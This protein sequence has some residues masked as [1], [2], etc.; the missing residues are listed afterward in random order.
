MSRHAAMALIL[1]APLAA[2]IQPAQAQ[3]AQ[4]PDWPCV[5]VLVPELAMGQMW[6]GPP[7][8]AKP[9]AADAEI[10]PLALT[11]ARPAVPLDDAKRKAE[12]FAKSQAHGRSERLALLFQGTLE[13]INGERSRLLNGIR[14]YSRNQRALAEKI[15]VQGEALADLPVSPDAPV[16][17]ELLPLKQTQDWD[18]RIFEDRQKSL[19][20]LCD[21]P[22]LLE[23]R[24]FELGRALAG[25][26]P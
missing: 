13:I 15:N 9:W 4:D 10:A 1:L 16:P 2:L 14:N 6:S 25:M 3:P 11:L 8:P 20:Y 22:V 7:P 5:Q 26:Q 12:A 19:K 23:Q 18:I 17:P 21:Q 24:A